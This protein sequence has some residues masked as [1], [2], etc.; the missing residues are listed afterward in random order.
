[1]FE[2]IKHDLKKYY[3]VQEDG[4]KLPAVLS[5]LLCREFFSI[6]VYRFGYHIYSNRNIAVRFFFRPFYLFLDLI[7]RITCGIII[8]A[9][10]KIGPGLYI[11]HAGLLIIHPKAII[12]RDCSIAH[13]VTIG[14]LGGGKMGVPVIGDNV[15]ISSG[16][17]VLGP[18]R[19][20]NNVKIGANA[21]VIKDIPDNATAVGVPA[22]IV[23]K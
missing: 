23:K 17:R 13:D 21:V 10:C 3:H 8:P 19:V 4:K 22:R 11:G 6:L 2:N 12:G 5:A 9:R 14:T 1:V 20:G 7:V 16:A 15:M 18:I